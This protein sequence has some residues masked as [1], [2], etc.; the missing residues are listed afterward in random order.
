MTSLVPVLMVC[1]LLA[2]PMMAQLS[3]HKTLT[4]DGA[5]KIAA[6]A[7]AEAVK[8]H[9]NVVIAILDDGG[10]LIYL[11]RLDGTQI[12]SIDVAVAK[13]RT[14]VYY[15][16]PSKEF[17]NRIAAGGTN[18]LALLNSMPLE[19]GE[20]ISAEGQLVGAIGVSGGTSAEDG[21]IARAGIAAM[22]K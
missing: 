13:A 18:A 1:A 5:K 16:R 10:H 19:G 14:A 15:K 9:L 4:L 6:G 7:A 2:A 17:E 20:P 22:A 12:G 21:S 3:T 11:E 8:Q